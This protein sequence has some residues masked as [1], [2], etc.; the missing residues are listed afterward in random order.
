MSQTHPIPIFKST[1]PDA[2]AR[3][4]SLLKSAG[5]PFRELTQPSGSAR[6]PRRVN[7][8]VVDPCFEI[9]AR[10]TIADIPTEII[11][12]SHSPTI[13]HGHRAITWILLITVAV[14]ILISLIARLLNN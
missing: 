13:D 11:L 7:W 10:Q 3:A 1:D 9:E 4:V 2:I 12:P 6:V 8:I 5:I 14:I